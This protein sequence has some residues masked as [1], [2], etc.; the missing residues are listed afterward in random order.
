MPGLRSRDALGALALLIFLATAC[1]ETPSHQPDG[2]EAPRFLTLSPE[3]LGHSLSLSQLV[4]GEYGDKIYQMRFEVDITPARL[5]LVGLSPLGITLF[6]LVQDKGKRAVVTQ[7]QEKAPFD[8]RNLLFDVYLTY[9]PR[10]ALQAALSPLS[11]KLDE[12]ADGSVRRVRRPDGALIA[13]ITYP[14]KHLKKREIVIQHFDFPYRLRI[15]PLEARAT[16]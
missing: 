12:R 13:E 6:T 14:S 2:K 10:K 9:W 16:F 4:T 1:A 5:A 8:P 7:L 3:S 11:M 15:R